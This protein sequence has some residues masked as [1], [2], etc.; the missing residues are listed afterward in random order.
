MKKK[1]AIIIAAT[2]FLLNYMSVSLFASPIF[3]LPLE[4]STGSGP[5]SF[6]TADFNNDGVPDIA[7]AN[8]GSKTISVLIGN[9]DGTFLTNVDYQMVNNSYA[10][11]R[12]YAAI[13][14]GDF[15]GDGNL[16]LASINPTDYSV[17]IFFG[18]GNGSFQEAVGYD[19]GLYPPPSAIV[20]GD[21]DNDG[22]S[23][24]LVMYAGHTIVLMLRG[25]SDGSFTKDIKTYP[26]RY[27]R[28]YFSTRGTIVEGDFNGDGNLD[29]AFPYSHA[30]YFL[31][32]KGDGTFSAPK[33]YSYWY[34]IGNPRVITA[35]DFN[36]DG[37]LDIFS[38]EHTN[39]GR[40]I[41]VHLA[42]QTY[43]GYANSWTYA[44]D[45]VAGYDGASVTTDLDGDS[46]SDIVVTNSAS[47]TLSLFRGKGDGTFQ[48]PEDY[49]AGPYAGL[50]ING[51]SYHPN[52]CI[53]A[54][55]FN[56]DGK[57]DIAV[58]NSGSKFSVLLNIYEPDTDGDGVDDNTDNC[59]SD[60]NPDQADWDTDGIGDM[61]D[62]S[63]GDSWMD[64]Y[65]NCPTTTNSDQA[66]LD[67]DGIGN[68]C[69]DSDTDGIMDTPDNCPFI[70]NPNQVDWDGD[71]IGLA[72]DG[73]VGIDGIH[74]GISEILS[75][76]AIFDP[77]VAEALQGS[78][79]SVQNKI[80]GGN[81]DSASGKLGSIINQ[82]GAWSNNEN[83]AKLSKETADLLIGYLTIIQDGL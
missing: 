30:V 8:S 20:A 26:D 31:H 70:Y 56:Q 1:A 24:V 52:S 67:N 28:S 14:S 42:A 64:V 40:S 18:N 5:T 29:I 45:D 57:V 19:T 39:N 51:Y 53:I 35:D 7:S 43:Y 15:N 2:I 68:V 32:G 75:S 71:G 46:F 12:R 36:K 27:G 41:S 59:P 63:D 9:G 47:G 65:D 13:A 79:D 81:L 21:F 44:Y 3:D 4:F 66:D 62:D 48:L 22:R 58:L 74:N 72:C 33:P 37:K 38:V 80:D 50:R 25:N 17:S 11:N 54:T 83:S 61:C 55:D 77:A 34:G 49:D 76:G 23:D 78:L 69:D 73:D 16:D 82:L 10:S 60:A 6:T